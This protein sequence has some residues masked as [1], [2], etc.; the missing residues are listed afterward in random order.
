M[1]RAAILA[2]G[3]ATLAPSGRRGVGSR[4]V[5]TFET[6]ELAAASDAELAR[7]IAKG[8]D[9]AAESELCRRF[10]VRIRAFGRRHLG[11]VH[12]TADLV[13]RGLE[14]ALEK[15]RRGELR[16]P[17]RIASFVLGIARN[18][19]RDLRRTERRHGAARDELHEI[20]APT[21]EAPER[22][23]LE[24]LRGCL[25]RLSERERCVVVLTYY[26]EC[27][28]ARIAEQLGAS[29]GN[30]RVIRHRAMARLQR[31]M[32]VAP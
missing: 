1:S 12:A 8:R 21:N 31:C 17:E 3:R 13:E 9:A 2:R 19:A 10:A 26:D 18:A 20:A 27:P 30:V 25:E 14:L 22:V 32:E 4:R 6:P 29:E 11:D 24:R 15:L 23:E 28:A 5:S 7:R 16:E